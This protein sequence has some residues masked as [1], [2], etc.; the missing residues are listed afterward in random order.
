MKR[1]KLLTKKLS[2]CRPEASVVGTE[3]MSEPKPIESETR[4][5]SC[6][7]APCSVEFTK[8]QV[9]ERKLLAVLDDETKVAAVLSKQDLE[10]LIAACDGC[11]WEGI[12]RMK[13]CKNL[14]DGMRQLLREAFPP[15]D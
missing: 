1:T 12:P 4:G 7:P 13:R 2:H 10:D 6:A 8:R 15:N 9:I 3:N 14:A 5:G 11:V